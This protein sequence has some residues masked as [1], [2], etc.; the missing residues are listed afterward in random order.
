MVSLVSLISVRSAAVVGLLPWS[1]SPSPSVGGSAVTP[2]AACSP[3]SLSSPSAASSSACCASAS[4][5]RRSKYAL[6]GVRVGSPTISAKRACS[7]GEGQVFHV[8]PPRA[9]GVVEERQLVGEGIHHEHGPEQPL[10]ITVELD[11]VVLVAFRQHAFERVGCPLRLV[12]GL[13]LG[14]TFVDRQDQAAVEQLLVDLDGG[15]G[16]E[17][18]TGPR[19]RYSCVT[20][21]PVAASLPV[22]AMV[23]SPSDCSSLGRSSH[24]RRPPVARS[25]TA[26][27]MMHIVFAT[28]ATEAQSASARAAALTGDV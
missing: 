14:A 15:G 21:R 13:G 20:K 4:A 2:S 23:S 25:R 10:C 27:T 8:V 26:G 9:C 22:E 17:I 12:D 3:L 11:H 16:Q 28:L 5:I 18:I 7:S 24:V 1:A 6:F 19:T